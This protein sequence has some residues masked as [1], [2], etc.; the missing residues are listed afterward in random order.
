[1]SSEPD[2]HKTK[3]YY[4]LA[5]ENGEEDVMLR[6]KVLLELGIKGDHDL[7]L[8]FLKHWK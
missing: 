3:Y 8:A 2:Y 6:Y 1:M 4:Q 7:N 5:S